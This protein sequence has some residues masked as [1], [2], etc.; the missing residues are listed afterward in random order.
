MPWTTPYALA[1]DLSGSLRIGKSSSSDS[2]NFLFSS[3]VSTLAVKYATFSGFRRALF[4][5]SDLHCA[6]QPP[7]KAL[8]NQFRTTAFFP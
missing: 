4:A 7:V 3:G 5:P 1:T 6:V 2:A 8:G